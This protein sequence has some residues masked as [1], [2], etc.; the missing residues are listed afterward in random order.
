[1]KRSLLVLFGLLLLGVPAA[2]QGQ[3]GSADGFDYSINASNTN[4]ITI[5]GYYGPGGSVVIPT[6]INGL[7]VTSIGTNA[8]EFSSLTSVTIPSSVT[9]I[10]DGAFYDDYSLNSIK[11]PDS[12]TSIG[13]AAFANG[14]S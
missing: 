6:N 12:V 13:S 10:E 3:S 1:M 9:S 5:T 2:V 14:F 11:I 4:S 8:F 7:L